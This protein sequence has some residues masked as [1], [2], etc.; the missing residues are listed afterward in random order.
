MLPTISPF[1]LPF[2]A[3]DDGTG[4]G[5]PT[6]TPG[7]GR[8]DQAL[9]DAGKRALDAERERANAAE[10][11]AKAAQKQLADLEKAKQAEA[12][13]QAAEQGRYKELAETREASIVTL[14]ADL[15]AANAEL[16]ILREHVTTQFDAAVKDFPSVIRAFAPSAEASLPDRLAW[17]ATAT[18]QAK[19]LDKES[20]RGN[21]PDKQ[22]KTPS[23]TRA[24]S[25]VSMLEI[26]NQ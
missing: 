8:D 23:A 16:A 9:G 1:R 10:K 22:G 6:D 15:E 12:E 4:G 24:E 11:A 7:D 5:S 14:T 26:M 20:T 19:E 25:P 17:L 2:L 13:Q 3:P 21:G 18:A